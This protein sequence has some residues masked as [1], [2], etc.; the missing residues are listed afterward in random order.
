MNMRTRVTA[1][2]SYSRFRR[3]D[4]TA[5]ETLP[6]GTSRWITDPVSG[7]VLVE[8]APGQFPMGS[9]A[10]EEGRAA[11]EAV[12]DVTISSPFYMGRYEVTA[13]EWE[14]IMGSS[15]TRM[16]DCG[17]RCPVQNVTFE[18]VQ[19]FLA[20]LNARSAPGV[21]FRLPTEAEWEYAC[22]AGTASPFFAGDTVTKL[23]ANFSGRGSSPVGSFD[24]NQW[25]LHD[26]SGN[27]AEW[28]ADWY[29]P[30]GEANATDPTGPA[31][32]EA[33][34]VRGGGWDTAM[35]AARC[36]ARGRQAPGTRRLGLGF[37][38][39]ADFGGRP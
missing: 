25:G 16:S 26:M 12:R 29:A 33:R 27:V 38:V 35:L 28:T 14:A 19:R 1:R 30:Y 9:P 11:D 18:D 2:A 5:T 17:P 37:R 24:P 32:G 10:S 34:A 3:F 13:R 36:G 7:M 23:Q 6:T 39:A 4:A 15:S 21:R 20:R 31:S 22:R 8:L